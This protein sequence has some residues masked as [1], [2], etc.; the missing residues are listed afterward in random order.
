MPPAP[1]AMKNEKPMFLVYRK[2]TTLTYTAFDTTQTADL[3]RLHGLRFV[4]YHMDLQVDGSGGAADGANL[5]DGPSHFITE[6]RLKGNGKDDIVRSTGHLNY[7]KNFFDY[8]VAP[9]LTLAAV[10]GSGAANWIH[11]LSGRIDLAMPRGYVPIDT[12]LISSL[13]ASL[14]LSISIGSAEDEL[15]NATNDRVIAFDTCTIDVYVGEIVNFRADAFGQIIAKQFYLEAQPTASS[16]AYD[17]ILPV[18]NAYRDFLI[19]T[20]APNANPT[21][22]NTVLNNL[23]VK[24]GSEVFYDAEDDITRRI[25]ALE[26][27]IAE[28]TGAFMLDMSRDGLLKQ[29][30]NASIFNNL[31]FTFDLTFVTGNRIRVLAT[32]LIPI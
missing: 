32:E 13:F 5:A 31:K 8:S 16:T 6:I 28:Q 9:G 17:V 22:V 19:E 2:L 23:Q 12:A 20:V 15:V 4:D 29:T 1:A 30:L 25:P 14:Q 24:A 18:G 11:S 21:V 27:G 3:D 7:L 10:S 26:R